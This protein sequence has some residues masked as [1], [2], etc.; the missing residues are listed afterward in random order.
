MHSLVLPKIDQLFGN[1][2]QLERGVFDSV[3][4]AGEREDGAVMVGITLTIEK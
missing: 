2:G 3:W 1:F 4:P